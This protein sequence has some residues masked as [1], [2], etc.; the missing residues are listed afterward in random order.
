MLSEG[1]ADVVSVFCLQ[2]IDCFGV[3]EQ[4]VLVGVV[5]RVL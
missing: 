4:Q 1:S 5:Y 3:S 2:L